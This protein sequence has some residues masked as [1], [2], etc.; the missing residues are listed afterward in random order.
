MGGG[1]ARTFPK[2][3]RSPAIESLAAARRSAAAAGA[4]SAIAT[5]RSGLSRLSDP[6]ALGRFQSSGYGDASDQTPRAPRCARSAS[7]IGS[8]R[9]T[10]SEPSRRRPPSTRTAP[11]SGDG[12]D[13]DA[14]AGRPRPRAARGQQPRA[15]RRG[16]APRADR[17]LRSRAPAA[18]GGAAAPLAAYVRLGRCSAMAP[19]RG[20]GE[21]DAAEEQRH[22]DQRQDQHVGAGEGELA[23]AGLGRACCAGPPPGLPSPPPPRCLRP[24]RCHRDVPGAPGGVVAAGATAWLSGPAVVAFSAG[25][26]STA[27][28]R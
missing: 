7:R 11:R 16:G 27:R 23:A 3:R 9:C 4:E 15:D 12:E 22:P 28:T 20:S 25:T 1:R 24:R 19:R 6:V 8:G 14:A 13:S 2:V 10:G 26:P 21:P 17:G 18:P 5:Q